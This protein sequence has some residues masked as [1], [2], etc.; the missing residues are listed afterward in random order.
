MWGVLLGW[1]RV[2]AEDLQSQAGAAS[3]KLAIEISRSSALNLARGRRNIKALFYRLER[4]LWKQPGGTG[5]R[6]NQ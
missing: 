1:R 3:Q 2:V 5:V 6:Q 4:S